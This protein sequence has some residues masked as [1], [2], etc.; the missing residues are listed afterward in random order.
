MSNVFS[1][2]RAQLVL[3][4][5]F[6][7]TLALYLEPVATEETETAATD[8]HRLLY[9]LK[10][11]EELK[12]QYSLVTVSAI[13]AHEVMHCALNHLTRCGARDKRIWN[14]AAD[15]AT[16]LILDESGFRL[17]HG[18]L[19]D[20]RYKDMSTEQI[21]E[22]LAKKSE[23]GSG[24]SKDG[25]VIDDHS[26]WGKPSHG[27]E[28][29]EG[30]S[31]NGSALSPN[32]AKEL[33]ELEVEWKARVAAA[34]QAARSQGK[35]PAGLE[36]LID[37]LLKPYIPWREVLAD[38]ME[39]ICHE[40]VWGPFDRRFTHLETYIPS[41]GQDGLSE[42]VV[43]LDTSGSVSQKEL[44]QF[45][46]E[47]KAIADIGANTL[48][49]VFCDAKIGAWYTVELNE[50]LPH[51]KATGGGGTDFR[52]VFKAVGKKGMNPSVLIYYTDGYG[53]FPDRQPG[54]PVLW[55]VTK[56]HKKPPWGKSIVVDL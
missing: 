35:S 14:Y 8:G 1:N 51:I 55:A 47:V 19:L 12:S 40:Y 15:Y 18:A 56:N 23:Q 41:T 11:F 10:W 28:N 32:S 36:R 25:S 45:L 2:A 22:Q 5:P 38:Y 4:H 16:N 54:Y 7:A 31:G 34:A 17:P 50:G 13:I 44:S 48:H 49:I 39:R 30:G 26:M 3:H 29:K 37:E 21:Y 24:F 53:S 43:A 9:N 46:A 27:T 52:P 33:K 20:R 6:F 42:I